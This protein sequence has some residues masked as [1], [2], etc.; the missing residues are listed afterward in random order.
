VKLAAV[1][2]PPVAHQRLMRD[3][4]AA[5]EQPTL[6]GREGLDLGIKAA[7]VREIDARTAASIILKYEYLGTM[8]AVTLLCYGIY[9]DG[10]LGG[11]AVYSPEYAENLGV[12]DRYGYTGKIILLAR[13]ASAH[14]A[15]E[16][17]ASKLIRG[18]MRLLPSRYEVVTATVDAQAG[19]IGTIYQACGFS[20]VGRMRADNPLSSTSTATRAAGRIDGQIVAGRSYRRNAAYVDEKITTESKARYFAFRGS[21]TTQRTHA[22][23]IAALIQPYPKRTT[24][25]GGWAQSELALTIRRPHPAGST[26]KLAAEWEP[27]S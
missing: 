15:H 14:W 8:P 19:E 20:Y 22:H 13:G 12:W 10:L 21:R 4:Q 18:S 16:H 9:F 5:N 11:A 26:W 3:W 24:T 27:G 23:A 2:L 1:S 17:T 25:G 6:W 7:V